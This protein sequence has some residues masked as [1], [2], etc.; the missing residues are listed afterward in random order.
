MN[1]L[2]VLFMLLINPYIGNHSRLGLSY[3]V[4]LFLDWHPCFVFERICWKLFIL[5]PQFDIYIFLTIIWQLCWWISI[6]GYHFPYSQCFEMRWLIRYIIEIDA[7]IIKTKGS[8]KDVVF[9]YYILVSNLWL[10]AYQM[11]VVIETCVH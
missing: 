2:N 1:I 8:L 10:W 11:L 9:G 3:L 4:P 7:N 6:Q 5:R